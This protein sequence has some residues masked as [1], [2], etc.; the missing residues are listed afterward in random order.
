MAEVY[1]G[2]EK[3]IFSDTYNFFL[4]HRNIG[5][6]EREWDVCITEA[7]LLYHKYNNHPLVRDIITS[8]IT[9][10]EHKSLGES[11]GGY[12]YNQWEKILEKSH[13]VG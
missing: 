2:I 6:T 11:Y 13:M 1:K 10:L 12:T 8:I 7:N 3:Y 9:Q 4:R 5:Q